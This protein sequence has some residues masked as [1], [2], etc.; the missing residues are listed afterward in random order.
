MKKIEFYLNVLHFNI[1]KAHY[2][3]HLLA[4][5]LNPF[6]LIHKLPFQKRRYEKL[7]I[8][9][10]KEIDKAFGN[11]NF[12]LSLIVAGGVLLGLFFFLFF[13]LI[14]L[15]I[16]LFVEYKV[17]SA[18]HL[19]F[20]GMLSIALSYFFVF[21]KDKYLMYFNQFEKWS[22]VEKRKYNWCTFGFI[23][24][25]LLLFVLNIVN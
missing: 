1:Y 8:D 24:I 10:H 11:K 6:H 19:I 5:K 23:T 21:K 16:S 9:I 13:S 3:L 15:F 4:N 20:S 22:K 17:L 25:I 2:R 18:S 12:G 14:D 7:G